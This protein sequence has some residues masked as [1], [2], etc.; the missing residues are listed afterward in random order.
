VRKLASRDKSR[1]VEGLQGLLL[2]VEVAEIMCMKLASQ[3][4]SSTSLMPSFWPASTVE[5]LVLCD[6]GT[7]AFG[8][9]LS[10]MP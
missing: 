7:G 2:E 4:P 6:A 8:S 9:R 3:M 1:V 10:P 5:M